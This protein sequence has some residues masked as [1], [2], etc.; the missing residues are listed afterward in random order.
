MIKDNS[1]GSEGDYTCNIWS[2]G[3]HFLESTIENNR[4]YP[5]CTGLGQL[6]IER[7]IISGNDAGIRGYESKIRGKNSTV[8]L[9]SGAASNVYGGHLDISNSTLA[10]NGS[11]VVAVPSYEGEPHISTITL[12]GSIVARNTTSDIYISPYIK[13]FLDPKDSI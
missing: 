3:A 4:F 12:R 7:S 6:L 1:A 5:L 13:A 8:S 11:G 9:N 10:F 2:E